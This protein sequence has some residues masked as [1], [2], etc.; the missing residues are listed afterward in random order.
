MP[1]Y[2]AAL[3]TVC[4]EDTTTWSPIFDGDPVAPPTIQVEADDVWVRR[5]TGNWN[6]PEG[7]QIEG[8]Q[9]LTAVAVRVGRVVSILNLALT[10]P[11]GTPVATVD[12]LERIVQ[13][14]AGRIASAQGVS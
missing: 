11:D 5:F 14:M 9:D 6:G 13:A 4:C 10:L 12:D 1:A 8:S 2:R 3:P 7:V